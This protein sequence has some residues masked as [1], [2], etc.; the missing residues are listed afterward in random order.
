VS[1]SLDVNILLYASDQASPHYITASRFL[2]ECAFGSELC[3]LAWPTLMS[4]L[5]ITTHSRI[6]AQPLSPSEALK[7]LLGLLGLP[8]VRTLS[9]GPDFLNVYQEVTKN[10]PVRGNLV[11]DAHLAALLRQH[12][13]PTLYSADTDFRK[14]S[15]LTVRNPLSQ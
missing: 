8:H 3:Y 14:F 10:I 11:P 12:D 6:F 15:G 9:E 4:Y 2:A 7:N 1:F 13:I 5:R